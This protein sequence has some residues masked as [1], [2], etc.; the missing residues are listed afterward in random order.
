V[1]ADE[2]GAEHRGGAPALGL[3]RGA[4]LNQRPRARKRRGDARKDRENEHVVLAQWD[5]RYVELLN[6][7]PNAKVPQREDRVPDGNRA[8]IAGRAVQEERQEM[9]DDIHED[10]GGPGH[11]VLEHALIKPVDFI[12][13]VQPRVDVNGTHGDERG[14]GADNIG[15]EGRHLIAEGIHENARGE[16]V[17]SEVIGYVLE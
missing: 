11:F 8:G 9:R 2:D 17:A 3:G 10:A 4:A 1:R 6:E 13:A 16:C 15:D 7:R 5:R 12:V 14:R